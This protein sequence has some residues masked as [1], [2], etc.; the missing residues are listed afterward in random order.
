MFSEQNDWHI[1]IESENF[2][3]TDRDEEMRSLTAQP[4]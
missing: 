1:D 2:D 3:G 4:E